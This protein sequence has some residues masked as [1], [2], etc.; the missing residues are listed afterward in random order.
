MKKKYLWTSI[1][2]T[3]LMFLNV[4]A[5]K[6]HE[7]IGNSINHAKKKLSERKLILAKQQGSQQM[8]DYGLQQ[9]DLIGF[10]NITSGPVQLSG[11]I[12]QWDG[13]DWQLQNGNVIYIFDT[14]GQLIEMSGTDSTGSEV[15]NMAIVYNNNSNITETITSL[16]F[17]FPGFGIINVKTKN[18]YQYDQL[19]T[20]TGTESY[21]WIDSTQTWMQDGFTVVEYSGT[22]IAADTTYE[23]DE[24]GD[25]SIASFT[26]YTYD[27]N[28]LVIESITEEVGF[29]TDSLALSEKVVFSYG[30]NGLP[31]TVTTYS[32]GF[33]DWEISTIDIMEY[34]ADSTVAVMSAQE[35]SDS[36]GLVEN[37]SR[38]NFSYD[39]QG[40][41]SQAISKTWDGSQWVNDTRIT[42][43]L[44]DVGIFNKQQRNAIDGLFLSTSLISTGII[45][46]NLYIPGESIIDLKLHKM[47]GKTIKTIYNQRKFAQGAYNIQMTNQNKLASGTYIVNLTSKTKTMSRSIVIS[48]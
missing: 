12:A 47:N 22:D 31:D 39:A 20:L 38:Q 27:A 2:C 42:Y 21:A 16:V 35:L 43:T 34:N 41:L 3:T 17:N 36:T 33:T 10:K 8:A 7:M 30:A 24:S 14:D 15:L 18:V 45:S 13:V 11:Q 48:H 44:G 37:T 26:Y 46:I 23:I 9:F 4:Y 29:F 6:P 28:G 1:L 19:E 5:T 25:T 32:M 40:I